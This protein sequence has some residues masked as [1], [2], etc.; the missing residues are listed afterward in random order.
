MM[1]C[2][3][4]E[5]VMHDPLPEEKIT[6]KFKVD[7][8]AISEAMKMTEVKPN[9]DLQSLIKKGERSYYDGQHPHPDGSF[10]PIKKWMGF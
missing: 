1:Y 2:Q 7:F 8:K 5:G 3:P 4:M 6:S 10:D 9:D